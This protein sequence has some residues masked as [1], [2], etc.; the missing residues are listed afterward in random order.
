MSKRWSKLQRDVAALWV[1]GLDL[2][3]HCSAYRMNSQRGS[4]DIPRYWFTLNGEIIWDY[5]KDF[6]K[7][8]PGREPMGNYP[9]LTDVSAISTLIRTYIDTP[10]EEVMSTLFTEDQWGLINIL[11]AADKRIGSRRLPELKSKTG[12]IA[13]RKIIAARILAKS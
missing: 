1:D 10:K 3:L 13:A 7:A 5:P 8:H 11:R 9:Y 4:T 6:S 2:Q 12:N